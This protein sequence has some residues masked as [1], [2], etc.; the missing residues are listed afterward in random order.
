[1]LG[2]IAYFQGLSFQSF[3]GQ[4]LHFASQH[5]NQARFTGTIGP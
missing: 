3:T 5:L 2:E 1:M 4:R